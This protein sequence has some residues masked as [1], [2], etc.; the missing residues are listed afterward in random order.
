[1]KIWPNKKDFGFGRSIFIVSVKYLAVGNGNGC[2]DWYDR[3]DSHPNSRATAAGLV[4][5]RS[6]IHA[7]PHGIRSLQATKLPLHHRSVGH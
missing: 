2:E 4:V 3:D 5:R 6:L 1:M 7:K